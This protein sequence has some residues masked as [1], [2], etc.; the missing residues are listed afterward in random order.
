MSDV[1]SPEDRVR[2]EDL[3]DRAADLSSAEQAALLERECGTN[4]VLRKEL[5]RL[6]EGLAG[7]DI[8]GHAQPEAPSRVG[9]HIGPY[10]LLEKIGEGGMGE[11][12]LAEQVEP[13]ARRVAL[14]IIKPGM[15][16]AQVV[17]RFEAERQAVARM[18]H[19]NIAQV[20]DAGTTPSG[21]PY[22]VMEYVEGEPI[23]TYCDRHRLTT[24]QRL[25]LFIDVCSGVQHAHVKGVVHR[26]LKP[27]NLLVMERDGRA[28]PKIIDFGVARATTGRLVEHAQHTLLGQIVGTLDYMSPEQADPTSVDVD[29]RSDIYSLGVVLYE[30]LSGLL[31]LDHTA[32]AD[33]PF[34]EIQRAIRETDPPTPSTRLRRKAGTATRFAPLRATDERS[35]LR[36]LEG[37][38][39]WICLKALEKDPT[40]RYQSASEFEQDVQRH[41]AHQPVL[42]GRPGALYVARKFVRRNRL[43]VTAGVVVTVATVAGGFGTVSARQE[44]AKAQVE[45]VRSQRLT[46]AKEL[47]ELVE[48]ADQLWPVH[49]DKIPAL[50]SWLSEARQLSDRLQYHR[51]ALSALRSRALARRDED[52]ARD[53]QTHPRVP[54][55]ARMS[56][57]LS[58]RITQYEKVHEGEE[59]IAELEQAVADLDRT[60]GLQR[61]WR[62]E[63]TEDQ[64]QHDLLQTLASNLESFEAD[65]LAADVATQEHG[66]SVPKRLELARKFAADFSAGGEH[67]QAWAEALPKIRAAYPELPDLRMQMGLV[68]LGPDSDSGLWEFSHLASSEHFEPVRRGEDGKLVL[69]NGMGVVLVLLHQGDFWMG[70]Q[71]EDPLG[72]NYD[73]DTLEFEGPPH[74]VHVPAFFISKYEMTQRQWRL[75]T[76]V[77]PSL[78][79]PGRIAKLNPVNI[80]DA[81]TCD[82]TT[83]QLG[84]VLPSEEQWEYAARAGTTTRWCSGDDAASLEGQANLFDLRSDRNHPK[85]KRETRML[86]VPWDDGSPDICQVGRYGANAFGLHDVHGNV[87]EWCSNPAY[88][89][90]GDPSNV[91]HGLNMRVARGGDARSDP[92]EAR[93]ARRKVGSGEIAV[94][95]LG[96]R[97]ARAIDR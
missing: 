19:P 75:C 58:A 11:V 83:M 32:A 4:D 73:P 2:L 28:V 89:Y 14:K 90:T 9:T 84:L 48:R 47:A 24:R 22:F 81:P 94:P 27:T 53:R 72:H 67:E 37:D 49:P 79:Q 68:P 57:E 93:S 63:R 64:W 55:L 51:A 50:E 21:S 13:I 26:D 66:W 97:P 85:W 40:R 15:D 77:S 44:A 1:L 12:Y 33:L 39:D 18:A 41:L 8:L 54:E 42:A 7:E 80:V 59:E 70:C 45:A 6:L 56:A 91:G 5:V 46:D 17:A 71:S 16:S 3:F 92:L 96:L 43:A 35:L 86:P 74:E 62:F 31:P 76:G 36:Q 25:E 88:L 61:T 87:W 34:S 29:T 60:V 78:S 69:E 52:V 95:T 30:L 82:R 23:T 20:H 10:T 38:L 65:L